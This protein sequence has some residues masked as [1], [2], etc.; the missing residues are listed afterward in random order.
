M[1]ATSSAS[2]NRRPPG[3]FTAMPSKTSSSGTRVDL[4]EV[5]ELHARGRTHVT[6]QRRPLEAEQWAR[7][8]KGH[9]NES[10][11]GRG[12]AVLVEAEVAGGPLDQGGVG[13]GHR[14]VDD[15]VA[16]LQGGLEDGMTSLGRPA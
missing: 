4:A 16:V 8:H 1:S 6:Y 5:F 11:H 9:L 14:R 15:R 13:Q 12:D 10:T 2:V 7:E 3:V